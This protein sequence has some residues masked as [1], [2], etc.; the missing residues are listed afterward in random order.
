MRIVVCLCVCVCVCVQFLEN[1]AGFLLNPINPAATC[2]GVPLPGSETLGTQSRK[3]PD[4]KLSFGAWDLLS[5][6]RQ[7]AH[8][9]PVY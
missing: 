3:Q 7:M 9:K 1:H 6:K 2:T 4:E 5:K 8:P